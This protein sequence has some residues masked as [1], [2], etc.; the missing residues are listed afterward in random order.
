MSRIE[1]RVDELMNLHTMP[2]GKIAKKLKDE[3]FEDNDINDA[4]NKFIRSKAQ[5]VKEYD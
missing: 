1:S 5:S 2:I 4:I 3:G